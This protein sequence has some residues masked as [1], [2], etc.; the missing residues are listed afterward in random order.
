M[1][2]ALTLALLLIALIG[3]GGGGG[4]DTTVINPGTNPGN[5]P[6]NDPGSTPTDPGTTQPTVPNI[7]GTY[8]LQNV[9]ITYDNGITVTDKDIA[10][11]GSMRIEPTVITQTITVNKIAFSSSVIFDVSW[12]SEKHGVIHTVTSDGTIRDVDI[13]LADNTVTLK[14]TVPGSGIAFTET[15]T[16]VKSDF[17]TAKRQETPIINPSDDLIFIGQHVN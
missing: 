12:D 10:V 8:T 9:T 7:E 1:K 4:G 14:A 15:D 5:T 3:C 2:R 16:W 11:T 13:T 17:V 6:G